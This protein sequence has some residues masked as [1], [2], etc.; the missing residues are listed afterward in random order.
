MRLV[1]L[2]FLLVGVL[3]CPALLGQPAIPKPVAD[4]DSQGPV[5]LLNSGE[6]DFNR[7]RW[8]EAANA[9][10]KFLTNYGG[11]PD[12]AATVAKVKPLLGICQVRL[13]EYESAIPLLDV[14][15]ALPDLKPNQRTDLLF[16]A[17]MAKLKTG[18]ANAARQHLG[19]IFGDLKVERS[20]RMEALILGGM[21]YVMEKKW[22]DAIEFFQKH[23]TDIRSHQADA[24]ARAD[25]LLLYAL[26]EEK[27]W[28]DADEL[29][30]RICGNPDDVR[31]WVTFSSL[32][33]GLGDH[34]L[35]TQES[36]RAIVLLRQ[37]PSKAEIERSQA[38]R[39]RE[40]ESEMKSATQ[41]GNVIR[42]AQLQSAID[43]S[44]RELEAFEKIPQFDSAARFRMASAYFQM[45]RVREGCL[46][47]D[48]MVRQME[49]D[50]TVEAATASLIRG[51]MSLNRSIRADRTANLYLERF[52]NFPKVPNLPEVMFLKA[53]ALE[54]QMK[55]QD[56]ADG[57]L[58]VAEKFKDHA[59]APQARFMSAYNIL[60]QERYA[61]A[62]IAFSAQLKNLKPVDEIWQHV[63]FWRAM[64]FY[65]DQKWEECR[66]ELEVYL[67]AAEKGETGSEYVDDAL[68]R[69]GYSYFSEARYPEAIRVL[70]GF[71]NEHSTSEWTAEALLTLGDCH[72]AEGDLDVADL[73]YAKIGEEAPGFHDEGWMKRGNLRKVKKDLAGMKSHFTEFL[74]KRPQS[75]R[76]AE[77][78]QWLGWVAKQEGDLDAA[79]EIYWDAIRKFGNEPARPGI[80]DIF[81]ALQGF[82]T[83]P[84]R[85][86][87]E[88]KFNDALVR[89]RTEKTDR[90]STRLGWALAQFQLSDKSRNEPIEIREQRSNEGL[91][92]LYS[93]MEAKETAP[94]ILADVGDALMKTGD[95]EKAKQVYEGL[96]KWWPRAPERDRAFA[97]L[98][99]IAMKAKDELKALEYFDRFEKS[100]VMPKS[101]PD[102]KGVSLVESETGG[103]VALARA[104]LLELREPD[105]SLAILLAIQKSKAMPARL[106]AEA[107]LQT[108]RHH[109]KRDHF[110]E[111]LPYFEQVYLLFNRFPDLVAQA[112]FE[113][114]EALEKMGLKDKAREVYSE[115]ASRTDL[116][117]SELF[118][119]SIERADALGGVLQP[120]QPEEGVIPPKPVTR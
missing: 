6:A 55:H 24:G 83:G 62:E 61:E 26:I 85:A 86:S 87:L 17:G 77:A 96:R 102:E 117:N 82:Y 60:Q 4:T 64:T 106:R 46:I 51:W 111:A 93:E 22:T 104:D 113:R 57:Y 25:I 35:E 18:Q 97:G 71:V 109:V 114:G 29:A 19:A 50:E 10:Q 13:G 7:G 3:V 20:R 43:E 103:R 112:Y 69:I 9:F 74:E 59:I 98:G 107:F 66:K 54:G 23:G 53:Q 28:D 16:F 48:Q 1:I 72:A 34:F 92:L 27:R 105:R 31:Q 5:E 116:E 110:R 94:R 32:L 80:E 37:I 58:E 78:L 95:S 52:A 70:T 119:R 49:P 68:F 12:T 91:I 38:N 56:A 33:I 88:V 118:K 73:T 14:S 89:S 47:L 44:K 90:L 39:L 67:A 79:R 30:R 41:E 76:T 108:G 45:N 40:A 15:L 42:A 65:F 8:R 2:Q 84:D 36:H 99:F 100:S 11:L 81:M 101:A 75:P 63:A 21:S 115:L 120:K